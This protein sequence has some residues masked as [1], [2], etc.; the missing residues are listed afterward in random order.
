MRSVN[1]CSRWRLVDGCANGSHELTG[2][3]S[4]TLVG[5]SVLRGLGSAEWMVTLVICETVEVVKPWVGVSGGGGSVG[6]CVHCGGVN[7]AVSSAGCD[8]AGGGVNAGVSGAVCCVP[9]GCQLR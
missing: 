2:V 3:S 1:R 8:C 9:P 5:V 6:G 4:V 7:T